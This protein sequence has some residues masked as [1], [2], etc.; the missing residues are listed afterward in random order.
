MNTIIPQS[1]FPT[2]KM[3]MSTTIVIAIQARTVSTIPIRPSPENSTGNRSPAEAKSS[4]S[5]FPNG[6]HPSLNKGSFCRLTPLYKPKDRNVKSTT[7]KTPVVISSSTK[8]ERWPMANTRTK[9]RT[10]AA[11][12]NSVAV[13]ALITL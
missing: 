4:I 1:M 9:V 13:F 6:F 7:A 11:R 8:I 5:H 10:M 2:K 3:R 12:D